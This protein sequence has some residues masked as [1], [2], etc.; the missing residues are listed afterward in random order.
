MSV[1][2]RLE[3]IE[4]IL[5]QLASREPPRSHY[6][7]KEFAA[8]VRRSEFQVRQWCNRGRIRAEKS[9]T[10]T[11]PSSAWVISHDELERYR[12]EGLLPEDPRRN[13]PDRGR[14]A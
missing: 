14:A 7:T 12:R 9:L 13:N 4:A 6:S 2:E 1:E 8:E 11:G 3:R 10:R 5:A